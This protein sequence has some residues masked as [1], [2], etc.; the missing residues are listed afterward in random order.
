MEIVDVFLGMVDISEFEIVFMFRLF[1]KWIFFE[2][3]VVV[4]LCW[5]KND[6]EIY[7]VII[8][9]RRRDF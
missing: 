2:S 5:V 1:R 4:I 8:R 7:L 6:F 9:I 3:I